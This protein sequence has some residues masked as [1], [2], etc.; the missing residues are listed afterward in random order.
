MKNEEIVKIVADSF[1]VSA[2]RMSSKDRSEDVTTAK[3]A[4][5]G[6]TKAYLKATTVNVLIGV[7]APSLRKYVAQCGE[8]LKSDKEFSKRYKEAEVKL[9][10]TI[11]SINL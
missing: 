5:S 4:F 10:E 1:G 7:S 9:K 3:I 6:L 8:L 2:V 11:K